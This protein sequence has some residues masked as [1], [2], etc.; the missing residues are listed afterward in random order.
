MENMMNWMDETNSRQKQAYELVAHTN[1]SFFLTGRAGTGKTTSLKN[2]QEHTGK[3]F[4]VVAPTGIAAIVAGGVTIHSFFGLD[5]NVQGP[6]DHGKNF[7][8][9]KIEAVRACDTI[10]IDEVSMVRCD[11][12]DAIDRTLRIIT[13]SSLP[14]GGKQII[15]SGDM[16]QLPPVLRSGAE[17][18]AMKAYYGTDIPFFFK[19]HV[20]EQMTLPTIEF[21]KVYRQDEVHFQRI[22]DNVRKGEC[23]EMD[24]FQLN[25]R[26]VEPASSDDPIIS[27]TPFKET[28]QKINDLQLNAI[29]EKE[30]VYE[31]IID[32]KF[33]K[34]D[35]DGN[36]K[37]DNLPAPLKL[38]LKVGAQVMFTRNDP[39]HRWVNGTLGTV[40]ELNESQIKVKVGNDLHDVTSVIWESFEYE[41]DKATKKFS[42]ETAGTFTQFPLR[43]AWAITIHKSQG[44]TFDNMIL[45]L[46]RGTFA[47]GQLYVALSRVRT[48]GGLYLTRPVKAS[49]FRK[50]DEVMAFTANFNNDSV[51]E[52]QLAEGKA[53]YPYLKS[54]DYDGAVAQYMELAK[55]ILLKG[56]HR[57]ASIL[58]KKMMNI[59]IADD[60]LTDSCR[61]IPLNENN[62]CVA[63]FNN[64]IICLYGG[65]PELAV[66]YADKVLATRTV[67]ESMYIKARAL[68][69]MGRTDL[70]DEVNVEMSRFL[71]QEGGKGYDAK[72]ICSLAQVNEAIGDPSLGGY[73]EVVLRHPEYIQGQVKFFMAMKRQHMKLVLAEDHELP[74]LAILFN[75]AQ[76]VDEFVESLK[77]IIAEDKEELAK[78]IDTVR[79]Q[80]LE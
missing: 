57:T 31:G 78:F 69:K 43:L 71:N 74:A 66:K 22:L 55:D 33:G 73:Q 62:N 46:S 54:C 53:L 38:T 15:F 34:K 30:F 75:G 25:S 80:I 79:K 19:A 20:F 28:A 32:G 51:I 10:I 35:K 40:S 7:T 47:A 65:N 8:D 67:Y 16:F 76:S 59:M 18:E 17:S 64:S 42:K 5:L 6:K 37:D 11:I 50:D 56:D 21:V 77:T 70:A 12:V 13:K 52:Q 1:Q 72:F 39:A 2:I 61:D 4:I 9:E 29:D 44:L 3:Q 49:D 63:W 45:D 58:F 23:S 36:I 27:L 26:C 60:V 48:L 68:Y 24:L 14:F 41:F